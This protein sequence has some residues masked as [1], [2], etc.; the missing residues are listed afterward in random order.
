MVRLASQYDLGLAAEIGET[1]NRNI[2]LT[3]KLFTY[4]LAGV[5]I[6]ASDIDAHTQLA[7]ELGEAMSHFSE[8]KPGRTGA[9]IG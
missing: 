9:R 6:L 5:P 8:A 3:N 4:L 7:S 1:P 2:S